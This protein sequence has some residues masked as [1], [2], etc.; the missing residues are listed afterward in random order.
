M[1]ELY[2][3]NAIDLGTFKERRGQLDSQ[4]LA[5]AAEL[6]EMDASAPEEGAPDI[7]ADALVREFKQ[8]Q[9]TFVELPM[10]NKQRLLQ[11]LTREVT[12]HK[13]GT[14]KIHLSLIAGIQSPAIPIDKYFEIHVAPKGR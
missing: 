9:A 7:D 11:D 10:P 13:D 12:A 5:I 6:T 8:L 2:E 14:V 4:R 3:T 1:L